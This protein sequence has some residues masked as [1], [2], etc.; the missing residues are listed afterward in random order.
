M[1]T[2]VDAVVLTVLMLLVFAAQ[3]V[4]G[5]IF[6]GASGV[7]GVSEGA[8][9]TVG[10]VLSLLNVVVIVALFFG[11]Y[12]YL[13]GRKGQTVGKMVVGI[14]VVREDTGGVPGTKAA[15]VRT[16]LRVVDGFF[17]YLVGY[18]VAASSQ[19]RQ[20]LGDM[21]ARTLVVRK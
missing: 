2:L 20:R 12:V 4:V 14:K 3:W 8:Q 11:Y 9:L 19:R 1:A 13:E 21:A 6:L 16:L 18:L 15:L 5:L 17:G 7:S 10:L